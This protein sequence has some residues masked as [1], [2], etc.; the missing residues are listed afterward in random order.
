MQQQKIIKHFIEER[1]WQP[2]HTPKELLLAIVE[3]IGEF[4][5]IIKWEPK[6]EKV[7]EKIKKHRDEVEDFFGDIVWDLCSLA[8]YCQVDISKALDDVIKKHEI[9]YPK[10][11]VGGR[12]INE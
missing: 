11:I 8:N 9:R 10:D 6:E 3:E 7:K 1:Q 12:H 2:Y 4:R 5:N